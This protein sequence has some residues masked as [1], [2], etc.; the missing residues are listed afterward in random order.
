M[1]PTTGGKAVAKKGAASPE[2]EIPAGQDRDPRPPRRETLAAVQGRLLDP[3]TALTIKGVE[4]RPTVYVGPRLVASARWDGADL[5]ER[6]QKVAEPLN[7]E[8][9]V[10]KTF[11]R[12]RVDGSRIDAGPLGVSRFVLSVRDERA[13]QAP[14]G[15][16]L[17]QQA[18]AKLG[19]AALEGVGLDH[20]LFSSQLGAN[21]HHDPNPVQ[22]TSPHHDPNPFTG[23]AIGS[24]LYP[25]G[26]GRQP[27]AYAGPPPYR[28]PDKAM[29]GRRRPVVGIVD[30]GVGQHSWLTP[31]IVDENVKIDGKRIGYGPAVPD[32]EERGD[33]VGPLDGMLDELSGHG[34]F[35][36]GLVHQACPDADI[37]SWRIVRSAGPIVESDLINALT[38][39]AELVRRA[40]DGE[41]GGHRLDVLSLSMGYYHE[42]PEDK[43]V[44][45]T[46]R[47]LFR[48][49]G[50]AG[51]AVVASAG[52]E[53]TARPLYPAAFGP[54][55]NAKKKPSDDHV[56]I[57][58]VGALNPNGTVALFSNTGPWVRTYQRGAAVMSTMPPFQGGLEPAARTRAFGLT[59]ESI[60]LD[61]FRGGFG[62][63]SGTS[64][65]APLMAGKIAASMLDAMPS[66][67]AKETREHA[68][69]RVWKAVE[70]ATP[71]TASWAG[72]P[73][74][75]TASKR[76]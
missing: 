6:L 36:A 24:Y 9:A 45:P 62:L 55:R 75:R 60:D 34:T 28:R 66:A 20:V 46:F 44:D 4:P 5:L 39:I 57:V 54:W 23:D 26:G 11:A 2:Q 33:L 3:A 41:K 59:R 52:N 49:M 61:D 8:V 19:P 32:P 27:I 29:K 14:D 30:T 12:N 42:T 37:T 72:A 1:N 51:C 31:D 13:A 10:D 15:W 64:F 18:R 67:K 7:W 70:A 65:A 69:A 74:K 35:I 21:P 25:G 73:R 53:A 38:Q 40:A 68:V 43:L 16:V 58:S 50:K 17:L 22:G 76:A 56:P 63:W 47:K 48:L 71:I